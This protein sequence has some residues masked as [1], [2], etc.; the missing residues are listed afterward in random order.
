MDKPLILSKGLPGSLVA[1]NL[2]GIM[3]NVFINYFLFD[4][5]NNINRGKIVHLNI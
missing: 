4:S 3:T 1:F 5:F 2:E